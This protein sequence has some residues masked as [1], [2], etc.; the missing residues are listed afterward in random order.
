MLLIRRCVLEFW[1][2]FVED[3]PFAAA[4]LVW[5]AI[6]AFPLRRVLPEKWDGPVFALGLIVILLE[7]VQ[8]SAKRLRKR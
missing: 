1:G 3:G 5:I 4:I 8:R 7:N 2:L 6:V